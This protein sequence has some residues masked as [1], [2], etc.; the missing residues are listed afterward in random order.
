MYEL[1]V[2]KQGYAPAVQMI[3]VEGGQIRGGLTI[4]LHQGN[5]SISGTVS[6]TTGPL[7]G[8][9]I[10]ASDGSTTISTVS[11]TTPGSV[12]QFVVNDLPT[13]DTL[14]LVVSYPGDAT[15]TLSVSLAA[16]QQLSGV[17]VTLISG[18]G[19]ISGTVTTSTRGPAG[20]VTVTATD[21]KVTLTTVTLST[22]KVGSYTLAGL[23][24][25]DTFTVT[26]SRPDLASQ[27]QAITLTAT[28]NPN[29]SGINATLVPNTAAVFGRVTQV[30][31]QP[32]GNV[33]VLLSSGNTSYQVTSATIP[34]PG[35]FEIDGVIPGTYTISFTRQGGQPTSSIVT[36]VAGQR[37]QDN[38]VLNPAA[39][40]AG[41]VVAS[42]GQPVPGAQ[43]TLFLATQFPTVS[44]EATLTDKNGHFIFSNVDSAAELHRGLRLPAGLRAPGDRGG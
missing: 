38:P 26:F 1:V 43:V 37:L 3:D 24:V 25:P 13:P 15:Q 22:G 9:T 36:L 42:R 35:A 41:Y 10:S 7:G 12:G 16:G 5:G 28:G 23:T 33:T 18:I 11:L 30:G 44:V 4:E 2:T 17:A 40:I 8:A 6:S 29:P 34:S 20:G 21:G 39:S 19:S 14:T 31:G 32:L 27:T